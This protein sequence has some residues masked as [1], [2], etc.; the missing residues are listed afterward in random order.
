MICFP[1]KLVSCLL[2]ALSAV[3]LL[4]PIG[5]EPI[6]AQA[7]IQIEQDAAL[8]NQQRFREP[9]G[10]QWGRF[11]NHDRARIRYGHVSAKKTIGT[12]V[13]V[14]GFTEFAEVYFELIR[15]LINHGYDVWAMDWHGEGGSDRYLVDRERAYSLGF[16]HDVADLNQ[17]V[18]TILTEKK[19]PLILVA[20][21]LGSNV[22]LRYLHDHPQSVDMAVLSAPALSVPRQNEI[23]L[24]AVTWIKCAT[25][26]GDEYLDRQ[27]NW[28]TTEPKVSKMPTHSHDPQRV[29]LE[30]AWANANPE[31]RSG[32]ATW[33]WL[34]EYDKSCQTIDDP[35][36][37][38]AIT[39]PIL[40]GSPSADLIADSAK[41][42]TLSRQLPAA[43]L[44]LG[45]GARHEL[46]LES[47]KYRDPWMKAI[48]AF[49][50][51]H[52]KK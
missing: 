13:V 43:T 27:G 12:V 46:F 28:A 26:K 33:K 21:S 34:Q 8:L 44:Y 52:G 47:D 38:K 51:G 24:R 17:F 1:R 30:A 11:T 2:T 31:L 16:D 7:N 39:T 35:N 45:E 40:I 36:Y 25:G 5:W 9:G 20:H 18:S 23:L 10:W 19:R 48:Y 3:Y 22:A 14:T 50:R 41:Q 42:S 49:I 29:R 6:W 4:G 15:D 32:G 37:L